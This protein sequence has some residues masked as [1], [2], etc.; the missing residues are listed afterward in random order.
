MNI[1]DAEPHPS[2]VKICRLTWSKLSFS[3]GPW[4]LV[5]LMFP[6][7]QLCTFPAA[8]RGKIKQKGWCRESKMEKRL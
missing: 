1:G 7:R 4:F 2:P 6:K 8:E 5:L 3:S